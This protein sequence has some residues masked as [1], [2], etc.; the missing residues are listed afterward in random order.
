MCWLHDSQGKIH[1]AVTL[2]D[3]MSAGENVA[4]TWVAE[5]AVNVHTKVSSRGL[6]ALC[7]A[8]RTVLAIYNTPACSTEAKNHLT[9]ARDDELSFYCLLAGQQNKIGV[10]IVAHTWKT[11][12]SDFLGELIEKPCFRCRTVWIDGLI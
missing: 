12:S 10:I 11:S 4:E 2:V 7:L 1:M 8:S 3:A 9:C 5:F 6:V